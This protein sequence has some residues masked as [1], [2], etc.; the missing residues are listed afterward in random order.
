VIFFQREIRN[1]GSGNKK[2]LRS[3][4]WGREKRKE[5]GETS[6]GIA[7]WGEKGERGTDHEWSVKEHS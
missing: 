3:T 5:G 7:S 4:G 1:W 6:F 2:F